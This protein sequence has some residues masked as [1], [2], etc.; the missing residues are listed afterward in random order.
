MPTK[1]EFRGRAMTS[2]A[3][4]YT[5]KAEPIYDTTIASDAVIKKPKHLTVSA[6]GYTLWVSE[7]HSKYHA[8]EFSRLT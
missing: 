5:T 7:F 6:G 4:S 8:S 3:S 1:F 2:D